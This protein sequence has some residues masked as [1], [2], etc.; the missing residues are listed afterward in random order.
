M[1]KRTLWYQVE[2]EYLQLTQED[3]P[4]IDNSLVILGEAG[5]GKSCLLEWL[6][7][8]DNFAY[9]TARQLLHR[10]KPNTLLNNKKVLV[11]DALDELSSSKDGDGIDLV[12]QKLGELD[13]PQFV[14]SCRVADWRSATGLVAI[15]E[16][17][18]IEPLEL[19]LNPFSQSDMNDFLSEKIG[20]EQAL[21]VVNHFVNLGLEGLLGNPQTLNLISEVAKSTQLPETLTQLFEQAV[22]LLRIEHSEQKIQRQLSKETELEVAGAAFGSLILSANEAISRKPIHRIDDGE[23]PISEI[24]SLKNG[25]YIENVIGSRLFRANGV[26]R[27]TYLHRRIG[28]FLG[29]KW[30]IKQ[31]NTSRKRKRLLSFFHAYELVPANLRGMHAWLIM[32]H[33]L[34]FEAIKSD[35]I[36]ILEYGDV[37]NLSIEQAKVLLSSIEKLAENN[38]RFYK[39]NSY[40]I[41]AFT[42]PVI[43]KQI[44]DI[45]LDYE[46]SFTFRIF[47]LE[48]IQSFQLPAYFIE[49][50]KKLVLEDQIKYVI[51]KTAGE[52]LAIQKQLINWEDIYLSL[53]KL[54]DESSFRLALELLQDIGYN[55]I[56]SRLI[57]TLAFLYLKTEETVSGPLW[58]IEIYLPDY[59][60]ESFLDTFIEYIKSE[61]KKFHHDE[62]YEMKNLLSHLILRVLNFKEIPVEKLWGWLEVFDYSYG[63]NNEKIKELENFFR[64]NDLLRR[65][66]QSFVLLELANEKLIWQ[67]SRNLS[68][69]SLGL[70][71]N[72]NDVILLLENMFSTNPGDERWKDIVQLAQHN[73]GIGQQVRNVALPF[74]RGNAQVKIWL[75]QISIRKLGD[76]EIKENLRTQKLEKKK[77]ELQAE[78]Q[79]FYRQNSELL[80]NGNYEVILAPAK[81]YLKMFSDI[82]SKPAPHQ[83]IAAWL[84]DEIS[85]ICMEGFENFLTNSIPEVKAEDIL[86][87]R[88]EGKVYN[89]CFILIVALAERI[90]K[91]I[92]LSDLPNERLFAGYFTLMNH[93]YDQ[94]VKIPEVFE[95]IENEL[96]RRGLLEE[97]LQ[98][99][100]EPLFHSRFTHIQGLT[101]ILRG[102]KY[103]NFNIELAKRWMD[104]FPFIELNSESELID[105]LLYA[106]QFDFL[107]K[108]LSQRTKLEN[109]EQKKNWIGIGLIID[110]EE[111]IKQFQKELSDR[112]F[113]W[114]I[115][116]RL[117][118]RY[119]ENKASLQLSV[120]LLEW[121]I[122]TFRYEYPEVGY[123]RGVYSGDRQPWDAADFLKGIVAQLAK[124]P[125]DEASRVLE[126]LKNSEQ[127]SYT[128]LIKTLQ[129]EQKQIRVES[130]YTPP[131]IEQIKAISEDLPPQSISD[132]QAF[133]LEELAVVQAKIRSDDAESWRGFYD[134]NAKPYKEERC[135]D[136]LIGLLRQGSNEVVYE[137]EVHEADDKEADIACTVGQLRL[138][139]EVK[140]QWHPELWTGAD[141]QLN[142]LYAQDWR[143]EGRG[144]YLVLWFGLR[145]D[146]KK[147]KSRGKGKP[148]P[149]AADQLKAMLIENSQAA[150]SG[151]IEI[152]VLDIERLIYKI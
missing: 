40:Q 16:Q 137:V 71:P 148:I 9:C 149:T 104:K 19:H 45:L 140:G 60:I 88:K 90:R 142:K 75:E 144:I 31:A 22:G 7:S 108:F 65:K 127:D 147:L 10:H 80:R 121:I 52:I 116:D 83:C 34:A 77:Q 53:S 38:P 150:K 25:Q 126:R 97:A 94:D 125:S 129:Y 70:I 133:I 35:P 78:Q 11:I 13:Y 44:K 14:L 42:T 143:A 72:E 56:N 139:I 4:N 92:G 33:N 18:N 1:I 145:T 123:P 84:S 55:R 50:L 107:K 152:V 27:F 21:N 62:S 131:T 105:S 100:Y 103:K 112:D 63:Y 37:D 74:T 130:L 47:L 117:N 69:A 23:L 119:L 91:K 67:R 102:A 96:L 93:R 12:L 3:L 5:M 151:Q 36:G 20:N 58:F 26:E 138:P 79:K 46:I 124:N 54:N 8:L 43:L 86:E 136:H 49:V 95:E 134:D 122:N 141:N 51:R 135:R 89:E 106:G 113:I 110:F 82:D 101:N 128:D 146:N 39:R 76:C 28:E 85:N 2:K 98:L 120:N 29:A 87:I 81:A 114:T 109:V 15:K 99:F 57:A 6:G 41:R 59:Q 32:D 115:R 66:I 64:T 17:Y 24:K 118:G 132:L 30:L 61:E 111:T 73:G 68:Q 48:S